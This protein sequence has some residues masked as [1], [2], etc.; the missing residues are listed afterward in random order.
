MVNRQLFK[1]QVNVWNHFAVTVK[2]PL[3]KINMNGTEIGCGSISLDFFPLKMPRSMNYIGSGYSGVRVL[4][5]CSLSDFKIF[6]K[7]LTQGE[8]QM[9]QYPVQNMN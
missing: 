4:A 1:M 7:A 2:N 6:D 3:V 9:Q 8:I 5:E